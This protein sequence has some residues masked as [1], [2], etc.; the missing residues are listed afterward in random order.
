VYR[1][2]DTVTATPSIEDKPR[3]D[4]KREAILV[5]LKIGQPS[6]SR[7]SEMLTQEA[8]QKH[9]CDEESVESRV[10]MIRKEDLE[11]LRSSCRAARDIFH[12][13]TLPWGDDAYRICTAALWPRLQ[14]ALNGQQGKA[15]VALDALLSRYDELKSGYE[16]RVGDVAREVVF[17]S[18]V[19]LQEAFTFVVDTQPIADASDFRLSHMDEDALRAMR[20]SLEQ[21]L[22]ERI[23]GAR[24]E[25]VERLQA[26]TAR[27]AERFE[28]D[29]DGNRK[30]FK[31]SLLENLSRTVDVLPALNIGNDPKIARLIE[32]V[33]DDLSGLGADELRQNPKLRKESAQ[34]AKSILTELASFSTD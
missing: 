6:I 27:C 23:K 4:L 1:D 30:V 12:K 8:A 11:P 16:Q 33:K 17:P 32:R 9:G 25:I 2:T 14:V 18:Q 3:L 28:D 7:K 10:R 19:E 29:Q 13:M 26:L 31:A 22:E 34:K 20:R 24:R 15:Q 21:S 5:R